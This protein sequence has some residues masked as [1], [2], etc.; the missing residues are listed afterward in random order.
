MP[1]KRQIPHNYGTFFITFTCHQ[2]LPLINITNGY[3]LVYKWFDYLKNNGHYIIGYVVMPNHIHALIG[4]RNTGKSVNTIIG[5]GK[6]FMA[7]E[8]TARLKKQDNIPI[9]KQ[10]NESV[11]QSDRKRGKLHEIWEDSFD[12]KECNSRNLIEQKLD[13]IHRNPC[14]GKWNLAESPVDYLHSSARFYIE[15]VHGIY[16]VVNFMELE[17]IDLSRD[18]Q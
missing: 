9:L 11:N 1:V 12:W 14:K 8:I 16:P 4:F 3:D 6:R 7:Y 13:Y 15:G 5:N 10:L 17:D 2:W 18:K